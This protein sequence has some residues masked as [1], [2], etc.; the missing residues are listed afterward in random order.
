M[1]C[2][3]HH[4]QT[5]LCAAPILACPACHD[6]CP[7]FVRCM[8]NGAVGYQ[9]LNFLRW[10]AWLTLYSDSFSFLVSGARPKAPSWD[11]RIVPHRR[12]RCVCP[13]SWVTLCWF[14]AW[15]HSSLD[16]WSRMRACSASWASKQDSGWQTSA[17][18]VQMASWRPATAH[19]H[20]LGPG[21][22]PASG[23]MAGSIDQRL[24]FAAPV[25]DGRHSLRARGLRCP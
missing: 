22:K 8:T 17:Y 23:R 11:V 14:F 3:Q 5:L 12:G 2:G 1:E 6:N 19:L 9:F 16:W 21:E 20:Q 15:P 24:S 13:F 25:E 4:L 7:R 18:R 10:V